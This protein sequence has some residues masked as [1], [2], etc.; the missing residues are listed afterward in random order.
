MSVGDNIRQIRENRGILQAD[1]AEKVGV[2]QAMICQIEKGTKVP[3]L[4][5]CWDI[6]RA[7]NCDLESLMADHIA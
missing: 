7:L 5:L 6:T 2:S 3:S 4:Q 1:L